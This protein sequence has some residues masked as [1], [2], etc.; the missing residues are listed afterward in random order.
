MPRGNHGVPCD[1]CPCAACNDCQYEQYGNTRYAC[2]LCEK[3]LRAGCAG[4]DGD[5]EGGGGYGCGRPVLGER[6]ESS[7]GMP[8]GNHAA[9][10]L[11][12]LA[13][14]KRDGSWTHKVV[15]IEKN[16]R[17]ER[18]VELPKGGAELGETTDE[19]AL[20]EFREETGIDLAGHTYHRLRPDTQT[21][22]KSVWF[23]VI[24][25]RYAVRCPEDSTRSVL[26]LDQAAAERNLREDYRAL[27]RE[28]W[29][30]G[31]PPLLGEVPQLVTP[32]RR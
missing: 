8:R 30:A 6:L 24:A 1:W 20:R 5:G 9:G 26:F 4:S 18:V 12:F 19:T 32:D 3:A 27:V 13:G 23:G 25:Q 2:Y 28:L 7:S 29:P 14:Q 22:C 16:S 31:P 21:W 10:V 11:A 15:A 17:G